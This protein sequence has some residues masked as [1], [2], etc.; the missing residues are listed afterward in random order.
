MVLTALREKKQTKHT[1]TK[2]NPVACDDTLKSKDTKRSVCALKWTVFFFFFTSDPPHGYRHAPQG[3]IWFCLCMF[4]FIFLSKAWVPLTA[5][6]WL[7]DYNGLSLNSL[8]STE[9]FWRSHLHLGCPCGKQINNFRLKK[10]IFGWTI[11]YELHICI[12][13]IIHF[14]CG[15]LSRHSRTPYNNKIH[16]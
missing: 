1:Q 2:L 10:N 8:C 13:I 12:I 15:R 6:I 7:T 4:Y 16:N 3:L 11:P 9:E 5:I 14:I